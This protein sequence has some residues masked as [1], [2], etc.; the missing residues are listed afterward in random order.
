MR[1][2]L[3]TY[4]DLVRIVELIRSTEAYAEFHLKLGGIEIDLHR[5]DASGAA[6]AAA[7][8]APA[9]LAAPAPAAP[10]RAAPARGA[11]PEPSAPQGPAPGPRPAVIAEGRVVVR[12]PMVGT[13]YR[14]PEP[15]AAPFVEVGERV[16]ADRTVCIIEVMKLMNSIPAGCAGRVEQILVQDAEMVEMGQPIIVID[17]QG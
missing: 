14:S 2:E 9:A 12:S 4:D 13:F 3:L 10:E 16:G 17:P 11:T 6:P 8:V 5:L 1:D 15:G 7:P